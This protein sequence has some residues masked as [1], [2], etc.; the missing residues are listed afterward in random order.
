LRH[1]LAAL[2]GKGALREPA[3]DGTSITVSEVRVSADLRHATAFVMP[4]GG[5]KAAEAITALKRGA[6][7]L[8]GVLAREVGLRRVPDLTF[9]LDPTFDRAEWITALL[10]RPEVARD[11]HP[12]GVEREPQEDGARTPEAE[13]PDK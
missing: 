13:R 5:E 2:L 11:L 10:A 6:P 1:A 9:A 7:F 4:L 12:A 8:K 3:L